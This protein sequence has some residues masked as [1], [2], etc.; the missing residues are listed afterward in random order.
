MTLTKK[1]MTF[2]NKIRKTNILSTLSAKDCRF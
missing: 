2:V 1:K